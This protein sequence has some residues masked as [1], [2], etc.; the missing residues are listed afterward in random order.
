MIMR[1]PLRKIL[2]VL[3]GR[4]LASSNPVR[5]LASR[6]G[7]VFSILLGI[8]GFL[9]ALIP[10]INILG[11]FIALI[12]VGVGFMALRQ[13][14]LS[15]SPKR[16]AVTG[17]VISFLALFVAMGLANSFFDNDKD[18]KKPATEQN[19]KGEW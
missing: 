14:R 6:V 19:E 13:A 18:G 11:A 16:Y 4:S 17:L 15:F 9:L 3:I 5:A 1:R 8:F 12:G 7:G 2:W 10:Y